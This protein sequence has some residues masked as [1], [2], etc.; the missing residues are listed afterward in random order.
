MATK[1]TLWERIF[2]EAA[3]TETARLIGYAGIDQPAFWEA[4]QA[5]VQTHG[6]PLMMAAVYDRRTLIR[7]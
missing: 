5:L 1:R 3:Y 7:K 2:F 4:A 6:K